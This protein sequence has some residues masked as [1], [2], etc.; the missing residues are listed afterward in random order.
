MNQSALK[1]FEIQRSF[2][3]LESLPTEEE[4]S[5]AAKKALET[6]TLLT[7]DIVAKSI[8]YIET[9]AMRVEEPEFVLD[10]LKNCDKN[11]FAQIRDY[12]G[13]LKEPSNIKPL[14]IKC[15]SCSHEYEQT[16]TLNPTDFFD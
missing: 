14:K 11:V 15:D 3:M 6:V 7:M 13:K 2:V 8:E 5:E 16:F 4:R 10:F 9:P 1:Q 12:N